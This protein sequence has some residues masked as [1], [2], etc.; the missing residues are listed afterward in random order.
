MKQGCQSAQAMRKDKNEQD[1]PKSLPPND[2]SNEIEVGIDNE[3]HEEK[4]D[5]QGGEEEDKNQGGEGRCQRDLRE[6]L[7][8]HRGG[9]GQTRNPEAFVLLLFYYSKCGVCM[10]LLLWLLLRESAAAGPWGDCIHWRG[11]IASLACDGLADSPATPHPTP[12]DTRDTHPNRRRP[13]LH[14]R[15]VPVPGR[16]FSSLTPVTHPLQPK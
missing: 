4:L 13:S 9:S 5:W 15:S 10:A 2:G 1:G 16:H 14:P 11:R 12:L 3:K 7:E 6:S 8:R